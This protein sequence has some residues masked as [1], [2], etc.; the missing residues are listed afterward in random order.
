M[1]DTKRGGFDWLFVDNEVDLMLD[2]V[3]CH[4]AMRVIEAI[5]SSLT[6]SL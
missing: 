6:I 5:T 1:A 3:S 2:G 4:K